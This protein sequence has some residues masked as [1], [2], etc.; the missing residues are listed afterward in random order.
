MSTISTLRPSPDRQAGVTKRIGAILVPVIAGALLGAAGV[1]VA[2]VLH[3]TLTV[4]MD[5]SLP[6]RFASGFYDSERSGDTTFAWTSQRAEIKLADVNRQIGWTCSVR[7]RGARSDPAT[8]PSVDV[9]VDGIIATAMQA[10]NDFQDAA[11]VLPP[12]S[13]S[14]AVVT[15]TS[16]STI[17]PSPSD[18][19]ELGVQIDR[20]VC[21]PQARIAWPPSGTIRDAALTGA[22]FG[23]ACALAGLTLGFALAATLVVTAA[24]ALPLSV[25][26]APYLSFSTTMV[27]FATWIAIVTVAMVAVL[28]RLRTRRL[29]HSA[30]V[31]IVVSAAVLYL[32]LL[33]LLHPSKLLVDAVFHAHRFE[34]VLAGRYFFTQRMPSGVSFP[35]AIGLYVFALPWSIFTH[36]HVSLLRVIVCSAQTIAGALLYPLLVKEWGDRVAAATAVVLFQF[37]PLPYGLVGTANLT[38]TFGEAVAL[39][40]VLSASLIAPGRALPLAVVFVLAALAFLS[41]VSTFAVLGVTLASLAVLYRALGGPALRPTAWW[42]AGVTI[43]AAIVAVVLYYGHFVDV[44]KDALRVRANTTASAVQTGDAAR[45][46]SERSSILP[47][48]SRITNAIGFALAM[49]GWPIVLLALIGVW[50]SAVDGLRDRASLA[51]LAWAIACAVFLGV[52]VM[53]VD[54]PFQRYAGEFFGRVLLATFPAAVVLAARGTAWAW[55]YGLPTRL[56]SAVVVVCAAVIGLQSWMAWFL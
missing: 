35:Y 15:V 40:A 30:R 52:A 27:W 10:T 45:V 25:G 32:K 6:R 4:E 53:R 39:A 24:Q 20:I 8:Q 2:Y 26:P 54:A 42:I 44:Y 50:R 38:N 43:A 28:D 23:F 56:A 47:L 22:I 3:P 46:A 51:V 9:A 13:S 17:V 7:L 55:N 5:R 36:D 29:Q 37:V 33:G 34:W 16:S 21:A 31:V 11:V 49:I 12:R 1:T 14:G 19:R 41:H 48:T 18:P